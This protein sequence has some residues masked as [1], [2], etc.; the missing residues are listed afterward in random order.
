MAGFTDVLKDVAEQV[1]ALATGKLAKFKDALVEDAQEFAKRKQADIERWAG[2]VQAGTLTL[3]DAEFLALGAKDLVEL[4]A[5]TY[6]GVA[7]TQLDRLK[8]EITSIVMK[9]AIGVLV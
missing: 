4:R 6:V 1:G 9:V 5:Q 7:K 8:G 3:A 2:L